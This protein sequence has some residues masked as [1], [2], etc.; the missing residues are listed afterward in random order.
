MAG[1][2]DQT[3]TAHL[4]ESWRNISDDQKWIVALEA[5]QQITRS[6][7]AKRIIDRATTYSSHTDRKVVNSEIDIDQKE[8]RTDKNVKICNKTTH[9]KTEETTRLKIESY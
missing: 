4:C 9:K 8:R 2:M 3:Q 5:Q 6:E 1:R 7:R